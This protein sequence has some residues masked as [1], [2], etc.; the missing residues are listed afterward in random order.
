VGK[1]AFPRQFQNCFVN[2][3]EKVSRKNASSSTLFKIQLFFSLTH[4]SRPQNQYIFVPCS[5]LLLDSLTG[6]FFCYHTWILYFKSQTFLFSKSSS[7]KRAC[8]NDLHCLQALSEEKVA[9][10]RSTSRNIY[11]NVAVNTLKKLRSLVPNSPSST[12]STYH[13]CGLVIGALLGLEATERELV[14]KTD[15]FLRSIMLKG[16]QLQLAFYSLA[17]FNGPSRGKSY[18]ALLAV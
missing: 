11:L 8:S 7:G 13:V 18:D 15:P 14:E 6:D 12:N 10:E 1:T 2:L 16:K 9:Y 4:Q 17:S 3:S 5:T